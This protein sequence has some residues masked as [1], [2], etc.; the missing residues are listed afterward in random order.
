MQSFPISQEFLRKELDFCREKI[1]AM[2]PGFK[3]ASPPPTP[4]A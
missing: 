2:L 3:T 4:R 1:G